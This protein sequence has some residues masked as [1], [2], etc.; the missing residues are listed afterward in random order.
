MRFITTLSFPYNT[1]QELIRS[2]SV[3]QGSFSARTDGASRPCGDV[4]M[5][6]TA[7]ITVTRRTAVSSLKSV[8]RGENDAFTAWRILNIPVGTWR[9]ALGLRSCFYLI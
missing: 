3:K 6:M 5:M 7:Q 2:L 8:T 4:M 1:L 9:R